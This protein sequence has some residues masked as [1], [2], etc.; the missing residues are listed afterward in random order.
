MSDERREKRWMRFGVGLVIVGVIAAIAVTIL[1]PGPRLAVG[2]IVDQQGV[3]RFPCGARK[4]K[5]SKDADNN[6]SIRTFQRSWRQYVVFPVWV[7][8]DH[9][10]FE[11]ERE[12]FLAVDEYERAWI[13][14]GGWE[15]SWGASRRMPRGGTVPRTPDVIAF[16]AFSISSCESG[17]CGVVVSATGYWAGVPN[18]FLERISE[19]SR[20]IWAGISHYPT[21]PVA[22]P[23]LSASD[24]VILARYLSNSRRRWW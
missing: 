12:W 14:R 8:I 22:P 3:Y 1:D 20:N 2:Q 11:S 6:L 10:I 15:D 21:V 9:V 16:G 17:G 4:V 23:S 19:Q 13:Y 24:Q 7:E 18:E 5:V